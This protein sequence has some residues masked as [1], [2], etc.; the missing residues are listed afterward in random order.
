[1]EYQKINFAETIKKIK[2]ILKS[3]CTQNKYEVN[4]N[5]KIYTTKVLMV[6][7]NLFQQT[8]EEKKCIKLNTKLLLQT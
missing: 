5:I 7:R 1:M 4:L 2:K 3:L 6:S 8:C